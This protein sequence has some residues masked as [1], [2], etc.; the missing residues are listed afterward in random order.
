MA[1]WK[2]TTP[3]QEAEVIRLFKQVVAEFKSNGGVGPNPAVGE[4]AKR[5]ADIYSKKADGYADSLAWYKV[6]EENG[7]TIKRTAKR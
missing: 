6:A 2:A 4:A 3:A 5:L 7:M 1:Q